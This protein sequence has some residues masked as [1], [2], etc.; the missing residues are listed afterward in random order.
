MLRTIDLLVPTSLYQLL[1]ILKILLAI[2]TKP[3]T[4]NEEVNCAEPS[5][6]ISILCLKFAFK[7]GPYFDVKA[8]VV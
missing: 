3:A 8:E 4:I 5:P 6:S 2:S 1:F 7:Y